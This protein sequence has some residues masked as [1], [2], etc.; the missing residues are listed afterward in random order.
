MLQ[1][2]EG[3]KD[4]PSKVLDK[5]ANY[6]RPRK[7]KRIARHRFKERKQGVTEGFDHFVKDL[8]LLLMDCEYGD[9]DDMLID[10]IIAGV[11]EKRVQERLLDKGEDLTLPKAIEIAQQFELSQRQIKIVREEESQVQAVKVKTKYQTANKKTFQKNQ[12]KFVQKEMYVNRPKNCPSCGKDPQH[13]WNQGKCPAKGSVCSYCHKPNHWV[14]VCRKRSVNAVSVQLQSETEDEE[15]L[16]INITQ[17]DEHSDDKWTAD[18]EI[19]SQKMPFRID[20]G[21]KCNTLTLSSYQRLLHD[22][23]LK[24]SN[25]VLKS[26]SN[27]KLKP[28]A[29]VDLLTKYKD[30]EILTEFEIVDISQEN[31]LS[32]ATAEA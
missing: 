30:A 26:Y 31:V 14:A 17:T 10:A 6:I 13:K 32:G 28:I 5:F 20:T 15:M 29:A 16:S 24:C 2:G 7:N 21:A 25:R 3:E 27:H 8:R 23:E 1:W 22:G 12:A 19:L 18:I 11:R 4:D 9:P